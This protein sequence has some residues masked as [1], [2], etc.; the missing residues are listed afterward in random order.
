MYHLPIALIAY[1]LHKSFGEF[2]LAKHPLDLIGDISDFYNEKFYQDTVAR[3]VMLVVFVVTFV[4]IVGISISEY[5]A[6]M[7]PFFDI[8]ISSLVAS[9]FL[10]YVATYETLH[11]LIGSPQMKQTLAQL[12]SQE[13]KQMSDSDLYKL[14]ITHYA[15]TLT[16][17]LVAPLFYLSILGLPALMLWVTIAH[18]YG[19][20]KTGTHYPKPITLLHTTLVYIPSRITALIITLLLGH[21]GSLLRPTHP[22]D[23]LSLALTLKLTPTGEGKDL[24]LPSDL[25]KALSIETKLHKTLLAILITGSVI[26]MVV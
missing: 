19:R 25:T 8:L 9:F 24:A 20:N 3:G 15:Q 21:K 16:S 17:G 4:L 2:K 22:I 10:S 18:L 26:S 12:T 1:L 23:A 11:S 13:T 6:I 5:L 14:A 7:H